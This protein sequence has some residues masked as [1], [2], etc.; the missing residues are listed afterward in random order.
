MNFTFSMP[1]PNM[2]IFR[3]AR[4]NFLRREQ[5]EEAADL[6]RQQA[7]VQGQPQVEP[8]RQEMQARSPGST[9]LRRFTDLPRPAIPSLISRRSSRPAPQPRPSSSC[10]VVLCRGCF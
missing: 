8:P 4:Q 1:R 2:D 3:N 9:I 7:L 5:A 6:E 10:C